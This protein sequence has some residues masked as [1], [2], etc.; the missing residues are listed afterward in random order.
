M[1]KVTRAR[2]RARRASNPEPVDRHADDGSFGWGLLAGLVGGCVVAALVWRRGKVQTRNGV[3][4]GFALQVVI[5][6]VAR[7]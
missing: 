4:V 6:L 2:A 1:A 3:V 5:L 7:A